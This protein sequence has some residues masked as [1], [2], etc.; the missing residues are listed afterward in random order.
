M[1]M[2]KKMLY[3]GDV[4]NN[5]WRLNRAENGEKFSTHSLGCKYHNVWVPKN[6]RKV[7]FGKLKRD[8]GQL[9]EKAL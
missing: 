9:S 4:K 7:V 1:S 8:I 5:K 6:R 3:V 2:N